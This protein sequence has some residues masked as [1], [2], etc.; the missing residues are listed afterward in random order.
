MSKNRTER[1]SNVL[2]VVCL[3]ALLFLVT[4]GCKSTKPDH[5]LTTIAEAAT[6]EAESEPLVLREGDTVRITFPGAPTLNTVQQIRR[7]GRITLPDVGEFK[8]TGLTPNQMEQ[9]L[10]KLYGPQLQTKEV[11]VGVDSS[12]FLVYVTGSVSRPGKVITDH[13]INALEAIMEAGG[14]DYNKANTKEVRVIRYENGQ[15]HHYRINLKRVLNGETSE[16]FALKPGDILYVPQR[17]TWF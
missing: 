15:A 3:S 4:T 1:L 8:A 7:D 10:L 16:T 11:A 13:P 17:F 5:K 9:E 12:A 14:F 2:N 6:K